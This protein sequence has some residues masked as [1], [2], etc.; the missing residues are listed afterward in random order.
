MTIE[1]GDGYPT[2]L[3]LREEL[4]QFLTAQG[5]FRDV[6]QYV[7]AL[8]AQVYAQ[9]ICSQ[10]GVYLRTDFSAAEDPMLHARR[11]LGLDGFERLRAVNP[12]PATPKMIG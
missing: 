4:A 7:D 11:M 9:Y 10:G 6:P 2:F 8:C 1:V 3:M 5:V 12:R